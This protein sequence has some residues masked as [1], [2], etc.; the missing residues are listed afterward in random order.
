MTRLASV[1]SLLLLIPYVMI[2]AE[3]SMQSQARFTVIN[4]P[5]Y[6][7]LARWTITQ[8]R[9]LRIVIFVGV[10]SLLVWT[11]ILFGTNGTIF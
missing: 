9:W 11:S 6:L 3:N 5:L 2:A 7:V 4:L 8:S 1:G 10:G